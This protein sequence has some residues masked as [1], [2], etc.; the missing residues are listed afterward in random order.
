MIH[1]PPEEAD[2]FCFQSDVIKLFVQGARYHKSIVIK[3]TEELG[4]AK[5]L[6]DYD[7]TTLKKKIFNTFIAILLTD[8]E[9]KKWKIF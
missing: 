9:L 1:T 4:E 3:A 6:Q 2:A 5:R 8:Y 7:N